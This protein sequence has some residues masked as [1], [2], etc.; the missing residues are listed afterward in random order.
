MLAGSLPVVAEG[1]QLVSSS[2]LQHCNGN[3]EI[4]QHQYSLHQEQ[5]LTMDDDPSLYQASP[6]HQPEEASME[7]LVLATASFSYAQSSCKEEENME[8][9][10][11][12]ESSNPGGY[13]AQNKEVVLSASC[14]HALPSS[15]QG[16]GRSITL[17]P[18]RTMENGEKETD[19]Q[20]IEGEPLCVHCSQILHVI[21][22]ACMQQGRFSNFK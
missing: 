15:E 17:V 14:V 4:K 2:S 13:G 21:D 6:C 18:T 19:V 8:I 10:P 9:T 12:P 1:A 16:S 7:E 22:S 11:M 3:S 20:K 5:D